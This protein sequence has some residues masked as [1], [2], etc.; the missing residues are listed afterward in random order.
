MT[1]FGP[2]VATQLLW[3]L[4]WTLASG[5]DVAWITDELDAPAVLV[6]RLGSPRAARV[7]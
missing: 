2:L 7:P 3:G 6:Q 4:S 5:A 1:G